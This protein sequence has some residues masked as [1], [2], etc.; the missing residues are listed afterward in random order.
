MAVDDGGAQRAWVVR[1]RGT[2]GARGLPGAVAV[3]A[4]RA[5]VAGVAPGAVVE[6]E[7][8][9]A[10]AVFHAHAP[11]AGKAVQRTR[12]GRVRSCGAVVVR[13]TLC[14]QHVCEI[15]F[16][17]AGVAS[18]AALLPAH[19]RFEE[20]ARVAQTVRPR[21][22]AGRRRLRVRVALRARAVLELALEKRVA[23][24]PARLRSV[25][26]ARPAEAVQRAARVGVGEGARAR[27]ARSARF[28]RLVSEEPSVAGYAVQ[29][30]EVA[31]S[32]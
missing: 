3:R 11:R 9:H 7:A 22:C 24:Q 26:E 30:L 5:R 21:G 8:L 13:G 23:A 16:V 29:R 15:A 17:R 6:E 25:L 2:R 18:G 12:L 20:E 14:A 19:V 27:R 32:T 1:V 4:R 10:E 28:R 31:F